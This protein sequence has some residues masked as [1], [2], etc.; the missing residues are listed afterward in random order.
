MSKYNTDLDYVIEYIDISIEE[1]E[2]I[3]AEADK[4]ISENK[5]KKDEESRKILALAYLKKAQCRRRLETVGSSE[6][7]Y[8]NTGMGLS[9]KVKK[10]IKKL[11][12]KALELST[13][14][15][16]A[17]MQLGLLNNFYFFP[18]SN[19]KE[20]SFLSMAIQIKPDYAAALNNRAMCFRSLSLD[21]DE[22]SYIENQE[23]R[24]KLEKERFEKNKSK[25]ESAVA[26]LT[27]AIKIRPFD[28]LYHFYRGKFHSELKE[29]KEAVEDL[30]N[31]INYAS[32]KIKERFI[33]REGILKLRGNNY[34]ELKEYGKAIDDF[35]EYLRLK[36]E[37]NDETLLMRAKAYYLAGEKDKAK[38]DIDEYL[39]RKRKEADEN[40][41]EEIIR[42]AG[43]TQEEVFK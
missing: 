36:P 5:G 3:K 10:G 32:E 25:I 9:K 21:N 13:D 35:S 14:M 8:E 17:F 42:I 40:K 28:S 1:L 39:N 26:D 37:Y 27:E 33:T 38:A 4:I 12:K 18:D 30:S 34:T 15:P 23:E 22:F 16:E 6:I 7:L 11:L 41:R 20:I 29:H 2:E 19:Y 24:D 43:V 31:A